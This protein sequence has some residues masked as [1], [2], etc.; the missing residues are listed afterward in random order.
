[1]ILNKNYSNLKHTLYGTA[2]ATLKMSSQKWIK[3]DKQRERQQRTVSDLCFEM[4]F[5]IQSENSVG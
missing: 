4:I 2:N 5:M 3:L 1:M